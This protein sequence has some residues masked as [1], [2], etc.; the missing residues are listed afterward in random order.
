MRRRMP[1][2]L[3]TFVGWLVIGCGGSGASPSPTASPTPPVRA[4]TGEIAYSGNAQANHKIVVGAV[5]A[6][7][8]DA[9]AYSAVITTPGP[10]ALTDVVDGTYLVFAFIDMG[11]D[12][13]APQAGEPHGWYDVGGDGQPDEVT[14]VNGSAAAG[15]DITLQDE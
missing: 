6:G 14:I 8:G 11:D 2:V 1:I 7:E 5:R 9:P 4:I 12:M 3:A 15:V 10:F 13:G